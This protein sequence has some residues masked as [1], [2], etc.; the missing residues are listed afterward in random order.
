MFRL[1]FSLFLFLSPQLREQER[2]RAK[3]QE[4]ERKK[5]LKHLIK[6]GKLPEGTETLPESYLQT[7]PAAAPSRPTCPFPAP[8]NRFGIPP[9]HLWDGKDRSNGFENKLFEARNKRSLMS[10]FRMRESLADL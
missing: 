10:S 6:E 1:S 4:K 9:G 7:M 5:L 2:H 8:P 3:K